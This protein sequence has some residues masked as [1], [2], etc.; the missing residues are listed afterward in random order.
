MKGR[1]KVCHLQLQTVLGQHGAAGGELDTAS[2]VPFV[3][4]AKGRGS[5]EALGRL[6]WP[7]SYIHR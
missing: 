5:W 2:S 6:V 7:G 1:G 3:Q 4:E